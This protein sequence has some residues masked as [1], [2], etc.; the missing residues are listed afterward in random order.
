ML[1][2][3]AG[4]G[5]RTFGKALVQPLAHGCRHRRIG[6]QRR[7]PPA[8]GR[9]TVG[10]GG[11]RVERSLDEPTGRFGPDLRCVDHASPAAQLAQSGV[12]G[13]SRRRSW[14]I[15]SSHLT[16]MP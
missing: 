11:E 3:R 4:A 5:M 2:E 14:G 16:Q 1:A 8:Q 10:V 13:N 6:D 7:N 9:L 15:G 12:K